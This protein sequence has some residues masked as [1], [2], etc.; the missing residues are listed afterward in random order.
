MFQTLDTFDTTFSADS[1]EWCTAEGFEDIFV[2]G[3]YQLLPK[4][5]ENLI[6]CNNL[7]RNKR[8]G[9][10]YLFRVISDKNL[11]LKLLQQL[12]TVAILD[13]KWAHI[14]CFDNKILLAVVNANG[15]LQ[16]YE[17]MNKEE[18]LYLRNIYLKLI[19]E[20][21]VNERKDFA[22]ALSLD[23][24]TGKRNDNNNSEV[25]ITV[26]DSQ[27]F[28]S[29]F[30]LIENGI[31]KITL[32]PA[33][34]YE[35]WITAFDYWNT[36]II[37]TGGDD[38]KFLCFDTRIG[39]TSPTN[40]NLSHNAGVTSLHCNGKK[41][42]CL[43]SGSYD[44]LLRIWDLRNLRKPVT[45]INL[46]GGIWRLKWDPYESK[47][48][49]A[50]CMYNG[51][52]IVNCNDLKIPKII[53]EYKEHKSI[54]YGCDWSYLKKHCDPKKKSL[55]NENVMLVGTCSFYDHVLKLSSVT[56]KN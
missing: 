17:L 10:I 37:Y 27:G 30:R 23:W 32:W 43:V 4:A 35:A 52:F 55:I 19:S 49:L 47:H 8:L 44:E 21:L 1:V 26:S 3:T 9:R 6:A 29:L 12:D 38:S 24:S 51:F 56:F 5:N 50:A 48:L 22:L 36:N 11:L 25:K 42:F 7:E 15:F 46:H 39:T 18:N 13:M 41:E 45:A 31:E 2:C 33:H 14:K 40:I 34:E 28:V 53:A 20:I 16:I 54:A